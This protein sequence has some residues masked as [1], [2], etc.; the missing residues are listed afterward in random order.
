MSDWCSDYDR[1]LITYIDQLSTDLAIPATAIHPHDVYI[2]PAHLTSH[3]YQP[4]Q[5]KQE[6]MLEIYIK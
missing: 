4:L 5:G 1:S 6:E 3:K 2:T